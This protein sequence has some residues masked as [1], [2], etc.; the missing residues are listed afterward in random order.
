MV[1]NTE[2]YVDSSFLESFQLLSLCAINE[3]MPDRR[4]IV[5]KNHRTVTNT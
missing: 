1:G 3:V 2:N 5:N 4:I